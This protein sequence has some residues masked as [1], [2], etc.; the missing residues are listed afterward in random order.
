V[1]GKKWFSLLEEKRQFAAEMRRIFELD[2][3]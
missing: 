1:A 3:L 2:D